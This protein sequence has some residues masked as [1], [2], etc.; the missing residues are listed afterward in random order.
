MISVLLPLKAI[1]YMVIMSKVLLLLFIFLACACTSTHKIDS[2][3]E[4]ER[5]YAALKME[6]ILSSF[7]GEVNISP[8][9]ILSEI[10]RDLPES[11]KRAFIES[12]PSTVM[13]DPINVNA[14][15]I[16]FKSKLTSLLTAQELKIAADFY[17]SNIGLKAHRAIIDAEIAVSESL[18]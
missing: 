6:E 2:N 4:F 1:N 7:G 17:S 13:A 9:K 3:V 11:Q 15:K 14:A 8:E 18:N 16:I 5:L 12:M 10:L